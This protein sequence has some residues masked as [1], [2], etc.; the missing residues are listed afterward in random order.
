MKYHTFSKHVLFRKEANSIFICD[1]KRLLDFKV[2]LIY[3]KFLFSL[4]KG[5]KNI[6][7]EYKSLF[8][9]L[10][11]LK[12]LTILEIKSLPSER[13]NEADNLLKKELFHEP[14]PRSYEFL[15]EKFQ[16]YPQYFIGAFLDNELVGIIQG[17][18]REDYLLLSELAIITRMRRRKIGSKLVKEFEKVA[19]SEGHSKIKL[20]GADHAGDFYISLG[21]RPSLFIQI[22]EDNFSSDVEEVLRSEKIIKKENKE[23]IIMIEIETRDANIDKLNIIKK[24]IKVLSVQ[25]LFTKFLL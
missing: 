25:Y 15:K 23:G 8:S 6:K 4:E 19:K 18:P 1:C 12:M 14:R 24:K 13:F 17:F 2:D 22:K 20:G 9:D 10:N 11:K 7:K 3:E 16:A 5:I 21:Y